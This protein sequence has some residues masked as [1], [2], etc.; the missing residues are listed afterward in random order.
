MNAKN[1]LLSMLAV[2]SIGTGTV[3][4]AS[5]QAHAE[6]TSVTSQP[7]LTG[8]Y[9][10]Q[11]PDLAKGVKMGFGSSLVHLPGDPDNV[12]YTSGD[13][14]PNGE[15]EIDGET[16]RTFPL[17]KY[18]PS[19]YKIKIEKGKISVLSSIPLQ[20]KGKD[21]VTG[22]SKITGLP[23]VIKHDEVPY[24]ATATK[25]ISYDPYGLDLEGLAYNPKDGTFWLSEEYGPSIVQVKKDGT[26]LQRLVPQ[27]MSA[28]LNSPAVPL[29]EVLP[30]SYLNRR[31]NRGME[32]ISITP[33][34]KWMFAAMQSP[35]RN[36]DKSVDN[37]RNLRILKIDM[38]TLKP[39]AEFV[40]VTENASQ[41]K[42]L[43]QS[44]IVI[45]DLFAINDHML[46]IDERD[47]NAG[48]KAQIKQIYATDL[49]AATNILG[50]YD[51]PDKFE[52]TLEQ[53]DM[54]E[55]AQ[56][57]ISIP[58]KR[59]VLDAVSFKYPYEKIEGITLLHGRTLVMIND[60]DFGVGSTSAEN[61]TQL[62]T[63]DLPT[64]LK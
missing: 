40:Y 63:F 34:G 20:V 28:M 54:T 30:A 57:G 62:W 64:T 22:T 7:K 21:P 32:A 56:Q 58:T 13:R 49:S 8:K 42:D 41:F 36:P 51:T 60:N 12:F 16:R 37:S 50:S 23:N 6:S 45:S 35:L 59:S 52:K 48:T 25:V 33:D 31:Q 9:V 29:K 2:A 3:M 47:K 55:F 24:D 27:G 1:F 19:I 10:L 11:A 14:G 4:I 53:M 44:D 5:P 15:V 46:L 26:I 18:T 39:V 17:P 38:A 43:K 61:G